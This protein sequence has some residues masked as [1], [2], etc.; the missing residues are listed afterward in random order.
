ML[1]A[2][3]LRVNIEQSKNMQGYGM[4]AVEVK[5]LKKRPAPA[6]PLRDRLAAE[7]ER[8][9]PADA[10]AFVME[11][12]SAK[13]LPGILIVHRGRALGLELPRK[14]QLNDARRILFPRLTQAGM[15]IEV[16][17]SFSE[18]LRCLRDMG[19]ELGG[20]ESLTRQVAELFR[21]AQKERR[22]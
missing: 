21:T 18:A 19:L 22:T 4:A 13:G 6:L 12:E 17:R 7:L 20:P 1:T 14:A 2:Y 3:M 5:V 9:L 8:L 11:D 16:A 15:R 10:F